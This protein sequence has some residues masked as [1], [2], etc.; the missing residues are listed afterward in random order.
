MKYFTSFLAA[1]AGLFAA[2]LAT[3]QM[4]PAPATPV[5]PLPVTPGFL[6]TPPA[7]VVARP[8]PPSEWTAAQTQQAFVV[9]FIYG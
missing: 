3:A 9:G 4:A 5:T 1:A 6:S 2:G 7:A 8:L